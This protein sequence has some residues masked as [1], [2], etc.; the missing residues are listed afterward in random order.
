MTDDRLI[1]GDALEVLP[2][3]DADSVDL[4]IA[5]PPYYSTQKA[6]VGDRQWR[7]ADDF[8]QWLGR[9]LASFHRVLVP[10][11]SL[12]LFASPEMAASVEVLTAQH[13]NVL[14]GITWLK[15]AGWHNKATKEDLRAYLS[16]WERIIFAEHY[17][18]DNGA[19][20]TAGYEREC[21][22][23]R[24]SVFASY[25]QAERE[26]AGYTRSQVEVALGYVSTK[27]PTRGTA[28]CYRWEEGSAMPSRDAYEKM[29]AFLNSGLS[30][31]EYLRRDYEELRRD[32]EELRRDYE[33]L[34]RD[35]EELRRDY[36]ELRRPFAV[37]ADMP[38]TDVWDFPTVA[39]YAG[40]H[41]CEKPLALLRHIISTSSKRGAVVLDCFAG[42]A[43]ASRAAVAEGRRYIAIEREPT[44]YHQAQRALA[45]DM[46]APHVAATDAPSELAALR[47]RQA[48][49]QG[50]VGLFAEV[51]A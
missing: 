40:K 39:A 36:E 19:K 47:Q 37:T 21:H 38:Y 20:A 31:A 15:G 46:A 9:V 44:Y 22:K 3:L 49:R 11:G 48:E 4:I 8:L 50:F 25:L 32:Y 42:S 30:T 17:G 35:Y 26:R 28:L 24:R 51:Q 1:L 5:D 18:A 34:R 33:E 13:F 23:M 10:N 29:R 41:P 43:S 45:R 27:D 7:S 16:P 2:T 6:E 12:Y 14:N